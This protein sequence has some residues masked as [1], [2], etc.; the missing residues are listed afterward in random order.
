HFTG[1][2]RSNQEA[3]VRGQAQRKLRIPYTASGGASFV[4]KPEIRDVLAWR[5]LIA[6]DDDAPAFIRAVTTPRRG[7]GNTT[8]QT[9]G[10]F[11]QEK[12]LSMFAADRKSVV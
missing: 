1:L 5:R 3:R 2:H 9:L 6:N 10:Q 4:E 12:G 7:V 11:A 8:L